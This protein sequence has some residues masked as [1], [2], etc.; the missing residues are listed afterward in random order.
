M[1]Q[2]IQRQRSAAVKTM[3]CHIFIRKNWDYGSKL[4]CYDESLRNYVSAKV[5]GVV[6]G[7][8]VGDSLRI[9]MELNGQKYC[10]VVRRND[11]FLIPRPSDVHSVLSNGWFIFHDQ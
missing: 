10:R 8:E 1:D 4:L 7:I 5:I 6:G 2:E 9:E 11:Y 3:Q